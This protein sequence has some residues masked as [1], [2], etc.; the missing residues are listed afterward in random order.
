MLAEVYVDSIL[1]ALKKFHVRRYC[2]LSAMYDMVAYTGSSVVTGAA[3]NLRLQKELAAKVI[4]SHCQ[5]PTTNALLISQQGSQM[6]I[7]TIS[8]TVHL[9]PGLCG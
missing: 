2:L 1:Q 9:R 5:R 4:S 3:G 7:E 8:L 6:G